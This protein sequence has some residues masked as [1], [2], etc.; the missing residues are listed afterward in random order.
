M[1]EQVFI[2]AGTRKDTGYGGEN[3][4]RAEYIHL[5]GEVVEKVKKKLPTDEKLYDLADFLRY[6]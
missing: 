2:L 6:L 3:E 4:E 5:H 1:Y